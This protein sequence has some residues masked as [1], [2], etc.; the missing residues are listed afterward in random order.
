MLFF[1]LVRKIL[2]QEDDRINI[3]WLIYRRHEAAIYKQSR[4]SDLPSQLNPSAQPYRQS[5]P[6]TT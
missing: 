4:G 1:K 5:T 6:A 3:V 2:W